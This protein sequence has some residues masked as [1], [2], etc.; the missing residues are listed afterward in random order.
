MLWYH[1]SDYD[2]VDVLHAAL[3][4][5]LVALPEEG[6]RGDEAGRLRLL[7]A[8][9]QGRAPDPLLGHAGDTGQWLD[10]RIFTNTFGLR[11]ATKKYSEKAA[12]VSCVNVRSPAA[13]LHAPLLH[14]PH[15]GRQRV[16]P[17]E[18]GRHGDV[19]ALGHEAIDSYQHKYK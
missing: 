19:A 17:S 15:E 8:R 9:G 4:V 13:E 14:H 18:R 1:N 2:L 7:H 16:A 5:W 11:K 12:A 6:G 3:L 10:L